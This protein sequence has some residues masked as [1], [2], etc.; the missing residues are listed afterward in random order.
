MPAEDCGGRDICQGE[1]NPNQ[2]DLQFASHASPHYR[3]IH[4][5]I[6]K[7]AT[8]RIASAVR[9]KPDSSPQRVRE[10]SRSGATAC[11]TSPAVHPVA[12]P[13]A[14]A[15]PMTPREPK[16]FVARSASIRGEYRRRRQKREKGP[17]DFPRPSSRR[18][19]S[20]WPQSPRGGSGFFFRSCSPLLG[21]PESSGS[22]RGGTHGASFLPQW[23]RW[24]DSAGC[25]DRRSPGQHIRPHRPNLAGLTVLPP[26]AFWGGR[27]SRTPRTLPILPARRE[28]TSPRR[29]RRD[30]RNGH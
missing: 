23:P 16:T 15:P 7:Q 4:R 8:P 14:N 30:G 11:A 5:S 13:T 24:R 18:I 2:E 21:S 6:Q 29:A 12:P 22:G 26:P 20:R 19:L 1:R 17:G 28:P 27:A 25:A 3:P 10:I 9:A